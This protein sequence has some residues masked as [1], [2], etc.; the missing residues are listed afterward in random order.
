[1]QNELL[2]FHQQTNYTYFQG[3]IQG[4]YE[5]F[6]LRANHPTRPLAFWIRYT[7]F[8]LKNFPEK[9]IGELWATFFNG[10][11]NQHTVVKQEYPL[12]ACFSIR[13]VL[14]SKSTSPNSRP[15]FFT[16]QLKVKGAHSHGK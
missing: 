4:H 1:M 3:Q 7:L 2:A 5:S 15:I 8:S 11:T 10:E 9:G 13:Q 16:G 6:F 12:A 14:T